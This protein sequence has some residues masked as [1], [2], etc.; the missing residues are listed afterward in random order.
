MWPRLY[1]MISATC[2][3][4]AAAD[5][6]VRLAPIISA[7]SSC[8]TVTALRIELTPLLQHCPSS[9]IGVFHHVA[10]PE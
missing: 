6:L 3:E 4:A 10:E 5:T 7:S 1:L 2:K 8:V 9:T